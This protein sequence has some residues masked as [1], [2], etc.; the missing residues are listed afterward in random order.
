MEKEGGKKRKPSA[1]NLF[2]KK[3]F[4]DGRKKNKS[5]KFKQALSD[6]AKVWDKSK[7]HIKKGGNT[8][9][10]EEVSESTESTPKSVSDNESSGSYSNDFSESVESIE[11]EEETK[12]KMKKGGK[13]S[14]KSSKKGSK[15]GSKKSKKNR[16]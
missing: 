2:V 14:K 7:N 16:K 5:Y 3:T 8:P 11:D 10:A 9:D 4:K 1:W 6:S 15:K 12:K 13:K